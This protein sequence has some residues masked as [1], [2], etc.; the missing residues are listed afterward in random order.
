[1]SIF[2]RTTIFVKEGGLRRRVPY[3][4][5]TFDGTTYF[6]FAPMSLNPMGEMELGDT[7]IPM[8]DYF[9]DD[10]VLLPEFDKIKFE[11]QVDSELI[12][13]NQRDCVSGYYDNEPS[14]DFGYPRE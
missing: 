14:S 8:D 9:Y 6:S 5:V 11:V 13:L 3:E 12:F 10:D 4:L 7:F 1:M 2:E